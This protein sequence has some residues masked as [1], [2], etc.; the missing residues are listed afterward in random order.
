M[1]DVNKK[2][3]SQH[4]VEMM[5][6][7]FCLN[8]EEEYQRIRLCSL[9][10]NKNVEDLVKTNCCLFNYYNLGPHH[11]HHIEAKKWLNEKYKL[12]LE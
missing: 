7:Y 9:L 5:L 4:Q 10:K 11:E 6:W 8:H 12:D 1:V 3:Y 2:K